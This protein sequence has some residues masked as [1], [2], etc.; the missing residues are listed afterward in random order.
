M[1]ATI[2]L[3]LITAAVLG[4]RHGID[5]DHIAAIS[6]LTSVSKSKM[7]SMR[8]A[9]LYAIGHGSIVAILGIL[10]I[11]LGLSL[12]KGTDQIM[13]KFVGV[14]LLILGIYVL[15]TFF[16]KSKS[17]R[18]KTRLT[19]LANLFMNSYFWIIHK[20]TGKHHDHKELFKDG[21]GVKSAF[22]I[23]IIHGIGAETP[24]QIVLFI[25]AGGIGGVVFGI[26]AVI[27]FIFGLIVMNTLM[28]LF[29]THG[30][31]NPRIRPKIY[32]TI[33]CVTAIYSVIVGAIFILGLTS[34]LPS[35]G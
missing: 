26:S 28:A 13:E 21:Y 18:I 17:V 27:I 9:F 19:L 33:I 6:D 35:L 23:G 1:T 25:L 32:N 2:A 15:Y 31:A 30:Y 4:F 3:A 20:L 11:S 16:T 14:T 29:F 7:E 22:F 12:P 8:L 24:T 10:A 34:V 5:Y